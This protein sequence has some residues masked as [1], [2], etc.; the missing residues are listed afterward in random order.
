MYVGWSPSINS[1]TCQPVPLVMDATAPAVRTER[2][3]GC[4][5]LEPEARA[6]DAEWLES[7]RR[8]EGLEAELARRRAEV[9]GVHREIEDRIAAVE[10]RRQQMALEGARQV[11]IEDVASAVEWNPPS[12]VLLSGTDLPAFF[13]PV[14]T[15]EW[16]GAILSGFRW[17]ENHRA[18]QSRDTPPASSMPQTGC[19]LSAAHRTGHCSANPF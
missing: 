15:G 7:C 12:D 18:G 13:G 11:S 1:T 2:L 5:A 14:I 3:S 19:P 10:R 6:L 17:T 16:S 4:A 8:V 9:L